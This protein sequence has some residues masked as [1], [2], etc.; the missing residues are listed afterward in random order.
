MKDKGD[1][2]MGFIKQLGIGVFN[3]VQ[4]NQPLVNLGT[5]AFGAGAGLAYGSDSENHPIFGSVMG[6]T[7]GG[8]A[9]AAAGPALYKGLMSMSKKGMFSSSPNIG[10]GISGTGV[11]RTFTRSRR[12]R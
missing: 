9:G 6:T 5:T 7:L 3:K 10:P 1:Y 2:E 4:K 11:G 12:G 8:M